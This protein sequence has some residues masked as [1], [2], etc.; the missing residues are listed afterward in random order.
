VQA[1]IYIDQLCSIYKLFTHKIMYIKRDS[2][3]DLLRAVFLKLLKTRNHINPSRGPATEIVGA[4]LELTNPRAR[5]SVTEKK[6]RLFS[7]IGEFLWYLS[8]TNNLDFI[9]HYLPD[10]TQF[11][12]DGKTVHGGY[13]PRLFNM[14]GH[15]QVDNVI[16]LLKKRPDSRQAVIQLFDAADLE[17]KYKD[18]PCTCTLQFMIRNERLQLVTSMRSNDAF[19]GLP[20]DVFSFTMLQEIV[21]QSLNVGLGSYKHMV[22]SLHL[23][24]ENRKGAQTYVDEGYQAFVSMPDLPS[25][26][27]WL[28]IEYLIKTEGLIRAG[29]KVNFEKLK[30]DPF[31]YDFALLLGIYSYVKK[32]EP[33]KI[34]PLKKQLSTNVY[35]TYIDR[36]Q[37]RLSTM[38]A[39]KKTATGPK[40]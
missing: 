33:A 22:G 31:W 23:Y 36:R 25:G 28:A 12:D 1:V 40:S 32:Q 13:G 38:E 14:R 9:S 10:Y 30:L 16:S 3:D 26:D 4:F 35:N 24:D 8:K 18:I 34:A 19:L 39:M 2:L 17:K 11:S 27:P 7:S 21:A 20:H 15:N 5:L 6:G 29:R 37:A